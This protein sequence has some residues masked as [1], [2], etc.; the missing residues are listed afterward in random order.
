MKKILKKLYSALRPDGAV[1]IDRRVIR[2]TPDAAPQ[3]QILLSYII[4]SFTTDPEDPV[5][6]SHTHYWE[7]RQMV[8]TFLELGYAV[9]LI[10][11]RNTCFRPERDY[12]FFCQCPDQF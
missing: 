4:E 8:N 6:R 2:L 10:S 11:Y 5:F 7:T 3:G 9:D 1:H 12:D